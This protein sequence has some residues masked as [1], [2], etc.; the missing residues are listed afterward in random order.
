MHRIDLPIAGVTQLHADLVMVL[1]GLTVGVVRGLGAR[2]VRLRQAALVLLGVELAQ[3]VIGYT[4]Y[5]LHV[6]PLLVGC[7]CSAP[8][9]SGSPPCGCCSPPVRS[10]NRAGGYAPAMTME[11]RYGSSGVARLVGALLVV[12]LI[13]GAIAA[14]Q[15]DYYSSGR[16]TAR[17]SRR[18]GDDPRRAAQLRR[19]EPEGALQRSA[20]EQ[21]ARQNSWVI[22]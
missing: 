12:W 21:V 5:F 3:G 2:R 11:R 22:V 1:I 14:G 20:A 9:W 16:T 7:T 4:Q 15:R 13:I 8:A 6:P 18:R 17:R 10:A 19:R